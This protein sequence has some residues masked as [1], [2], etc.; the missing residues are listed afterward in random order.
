MPFFVTWNEMKE[1]KYQDKVRIGNKND[2]QNEQE[3][4]K[5][6]K[7]GKQAKKDKERTGKRDKNSNKALFVKTETLN[8][9]RE[10]IGAK[11]N[12]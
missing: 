5:K 2:S 9:Y 11:A 4:S 12:I 1:N 7:I 6:E 10:K 8:C 3:K